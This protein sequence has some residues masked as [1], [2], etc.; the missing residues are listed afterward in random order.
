MTKKITTLP[1]TI[2]ITKEDTFEYF[3][4][5]YLDL[6]LSEEKSNLL[7]EHKC[8]KIMANVKKSKE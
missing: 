8:Q 4:K 6:G 2:K 5:Q 1:G 3:K 7:A